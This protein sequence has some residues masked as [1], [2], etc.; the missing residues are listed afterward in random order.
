MDFRRDI[1]WYYLAKKKIINCNT[2]PA[3]VQ[4]VLSLRLVEDY[5]VNGAEIIPVESGTDNY[6][7][8]FCDYE[9]NNAIVEEYSYQK[10]HPSLLCDALGDSPHQT[11]HFS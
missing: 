11:E 1:I 3:A 10:I 2:Q 4:R 5:C 9:N 8:R 6:V 7:T